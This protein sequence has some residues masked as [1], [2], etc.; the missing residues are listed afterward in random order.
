MEHR[1]ANQ[2]AEAERLAQEEAIQAEAEQRKRLL[3]MARD[4][5]TAQDIRAFVND[6]IRAFDQAPANGVSTNWISWALGIADRLDP[7]GQIQVSG[8]GTIVMRP[9]APPAKNVCSEG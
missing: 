7:V 6:V 1:L 8:D 2:R 4:H 5:R 9:A 3:Q